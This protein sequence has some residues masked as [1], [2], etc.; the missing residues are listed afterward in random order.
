M[1]T[2]QLQATRHFAVSARVS[3][4]MFAHAYPIWF[5]G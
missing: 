2:V 5:R 1:M 4:K 3:M